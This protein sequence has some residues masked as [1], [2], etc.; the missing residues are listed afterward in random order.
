M[1][2]KRTL[3]A[4]YSVETSEVVRGQIKHQQIRWAKSRRR[5]A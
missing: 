1:P 3:N 4:L 2:D 5:T